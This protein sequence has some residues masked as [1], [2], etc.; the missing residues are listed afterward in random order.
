MAAESEEVVVDAR[1]LGSPSTSPRRRP[2]A[3]RPGCAGATRS[4]RGIADPSASGCG[5]GPCGPPCR[6]AS[7]A[8]PAAARRPPG[9][10]SPAA[11]RAGTSRSSAAERRPARGATKATSRRSPGASSRARTTASRTPGCGEQRGLDLPQLDAEAAH[12]DLVV[13][14]AQELQLAV[15]PLAREVAGPVQPLARL[16]AERIGHEALRRQVRPAEVAAG[17]AR[18]RRCTARR[19]AHAAPG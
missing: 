8:A 13:D 10:M 1:P 3:P 9:T 6:W 16:R 15:R 2:A 17:Q 18:A 11:A 4:H 19:H 14:A 7:A 5:A 12:L